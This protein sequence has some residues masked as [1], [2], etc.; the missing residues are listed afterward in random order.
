M[1]H[2]TGKINLQY[3]QAL[4]V[5]EKRREYMFRQPLNYEDDRKHNG[6]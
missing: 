4:C 1:S 2:F 5:C 3:Y 6:S